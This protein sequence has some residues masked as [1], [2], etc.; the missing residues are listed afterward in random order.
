MTNTR[1]FA[2]FLLPEQSPCAPGSPGTIP[3]GI[4]EALALPT[5][6]PLC[7]MFPAGAEERPGA[8]ALGKGPLLE[9]CCHSD[10]APRAPPCAPGG[11]ARCLR[12]P[13]PQGEA[14]SKGIPSQH[15]S[16][17]AGTKRLGV[18]QAASKRLFANSC[19]ACSLSEVLFFHSGGPPLLV[20]LPRLLTQIS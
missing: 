1:F 10:P 13:R 17:G 3:G 12:P 2:G 20:S 8:P 5:S 11:S 4:K 15:R 18:S 19:D 7:E 9:T 14:P 6:K 16:W